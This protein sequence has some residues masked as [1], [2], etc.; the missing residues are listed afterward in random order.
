[1]TG[2]CEQLHLLLSKQRMFRFPFDSET[3]PENGIYI[4]YE[5]GEIAHRTN[6]IVRIGTHT[7]RNQLRSRLRQHFARENKDRSIFRKNIGRAILNRDNDPFIK[8]WEKDLTTKVAKE[9]F[10]NQINLR[11]QAAVEKAVSE[12]IQ[13]HLSFMVIRVDDKHERLELESR[14]ISTAS[15]CHECQP[16]ESWLGFYSPK[17]KIRESGLLLV[18]ELYKNPLSE[19]DFQKVVTCLENS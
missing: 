6:R 14:M 11:K 2:F 5:N 8:D 3:I 16:S 15:K 17:D 12:Y 18:N 19:I 13:N 10:G 9:K 7:G 4:L 1:M